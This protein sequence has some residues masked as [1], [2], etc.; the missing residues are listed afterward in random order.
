MMT[1]PTKGRRDEQS[2]LS[3]KPAIP[4]QG[5][6]AGSRAAFH[7][8]LLMILVALLNAL[9]V[10]IVRSLSP[11]VHPFII[12][13]TRALFGLIVVL[14][15][16][17]R[18]PGILRSNFRVRHLLRAALKLASLIA[19]F[20]AYAMAPLADATAIAFTAPIFVT[21][22]AWLFLAERLQTVRV[23]AVVVGFVGVVVVLRPG[24][25]HVISAGLLLALLGSVL[26]AVI[27]LVLKSMSSH[28]TTATLVAW[29]LILT[30]PL[31]IIPASLVW[32]TPTGAQCALLAL[33]G[34]LGALTMGL[35]TKAMSLAD[36][37]FI[38]PFEFLRLP[39]VAALAFAIFSETVSQATWVGGAIIFGSIILMAR[40]ARRRPG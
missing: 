34:C 25:D 35:A 29:N 28:D 32:T 13:F 26:T 11:D 5:T 16:I 39:F 14:P 6:D 27:Q 21:I 1:M 24:D 8:V 10:I 37:S 38:V 12:G 9:D 40:S 30:V 2:G 19:F 36:A 33:Q 31:A 7:G 20:A 15:W 18:R 22:G 4:I 17:M 3:G 23:V